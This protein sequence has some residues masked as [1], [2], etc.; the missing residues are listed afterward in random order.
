MPERDLQANVT[1]CAGRLG[2]LIFHPYDSR[3]STPGYPDLTLVHP[4][5]GALIFAELKTT[6]GKLTAAKRV[7]RDALAA[8]NRRV[9]VWRPAQWVDG[10]IQ[11]LLVR[12]ARPD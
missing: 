6:T 7:W 3:R 1:D 9:F 12:G 8:R 11:G 4:R 10:T 2:W 5:S